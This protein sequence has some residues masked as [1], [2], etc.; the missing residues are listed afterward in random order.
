MKGRSIFVLIDALGWEKVLET[1]FLPEFSAT[2]CPLRAVLGYSGACQAAMFSG[3][4]PSQT[5]HW[6]M[7]Y[8]TSQTRTFRAA[9]HLRLLPSWLRNR[10]RVRRWLARQIEHHGGIGAY[11][12][13]YEVPIEALW[14]LDLSDRKDLYAPGG[15]EPE[16]S[17]FDELSRNGA[18]YSVWN[19]RVD[20]RD[21]LESLLDELRQDRKRFYLIYW[22]KLDA[23]MHRHGTQSRVVDEHIQ[24]YTESVRRVY[25]TAAANE[26][27]TRLFVFSDHGMTDTCDTIDLMG[28][29]S[30]LGL[31]YGQDYLAFY[32][33][34]MARFSFSSR[35]ARDEIKALLL[36]QDGGDVLSDDALEALGVLFPDR[37]YGEVIFL[38]Q[39]GTLVVPSYMGRE[40]PRAMHGF[41]PDHPGA[42][43]FI[44]SNVQ[45]AAE[46]SSVMDLYSIMRNE[47]DE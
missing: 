47:L 24:W 5:G 16:S 21:S 25:E 20:E 10:G 29:I 7:Y 26:G 23:L 22:T 2:R 34:T 45:V 40:A 27:E 33:S 3:K 6:L 15:V 1:A 17:I 32:D 9:R 44:A 38:T 18:P 46:P 4:P 14:H 39:P 8:F 41:H 28:P 31:Q 36:A 19:W 13:L 30:R 37:R 12:S 35:T 42:H 43:A 11:Y